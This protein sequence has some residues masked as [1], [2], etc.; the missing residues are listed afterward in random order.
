MSKTEIP[1][2]NALETRNAVEIPKQNALETRN[3]V[4]QQFLAAEQSCRQEFLT[5]LQALCSEYEYDLE[6]IVTETSAGRGVT[7]EPRRRMPS[8]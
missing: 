2:Q 8:R 3:A 5:K 1:K 6:A 7:W 4:G